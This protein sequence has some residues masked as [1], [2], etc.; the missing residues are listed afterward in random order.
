M[1]KLHVKQI[2]GYIESNL[3][4]FIDMS[5]YASHKDKN[6]RKKAFLS[7][8]LA[9][10][11][12]ASLTKRD[13]ADISN[14]IVDGQKDG[15]LDV[16]YFDAS[17]SQLYLVQSK[18]HGDGH[19][20]IE[21]G[22]M[23][24]FVDGVRKVLDD[25]L[26]ELNDKVKACQ[27]FIKTALYNADSHF[28][29]VIVH[30]GVEE[31]SIE[32]SSVIDSFIK[33][34]NDTSEIM[35]NTVLTQQEI[36][37]FAAEGVFGQP[38]NLDVSLSSWGQV[39]EP[40]FAV[41]G[42]ISTSEVATWYKTHGDAL[43]AN[44]IRNFIGTTPINQDI[45]GTLT[46]SPDNFIYFNN[47]I[48]ATAKKIAK[49][50]L[51]G[52]KTDFGIFECSSV[53]IVN[54]AQTVGSIAKA[55]EANSEKAEAAIAFIRIITTED[56]EESFGRDVTK[57]TN[58]QNAIGRRDFVAL[59]KEQLRIQQELKFDGVEY[60][61]K[62]GSSSGAAK[63]FDLEEA[64]IALACSDADVTLAVQAKREI[65]KLWEHI[66]KT[67]YRKLFNGGLGGPY[68]WELVQASRAI[69]TSINNAANSKSG[70][71]ALICV[72][73]NRFIQW[74]VF[75]K[76]QINK[77]F[78]FDQIKSEIESAVNECVNV[79]ID[80]VKIDFPD[81]YPA[82]LFKN[83]TKCRELSIRTECD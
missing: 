63:Q 5:D 2:E 56:G 72:H 38:I 30:T 78:R 39:R 40:H 49:K 80:S 46:N 14:F 51:F 57:S 21:K 32:V 55:H 45:I 75:R 6:E 8:G 17:N 82:S 22:D 74:K 24:L 65:G 12:V 77:D 35:S 81:S 10:L 68:L 43:F 37:K 79:V 36:H 58:T 25:D 18:W 66:D 4:S 71:E 26:D 59:D 11:A 1:S 54:G 52:N 7:R 53:T 67:P 69:E 61:F 62:S 13:M 3:S 33:S 20:T 29:L 28:N 27:P 60:N 70:R 42:Q 64:T 19:G 83:S 34:H 47:G 76:F 50:P 73:G 15:G 48:T 23:S 31:L 16:I 44:N 9:V 41:Y